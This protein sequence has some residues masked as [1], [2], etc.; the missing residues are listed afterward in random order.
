MLVSQNN[1]AA[2]MLVFQTSP[3]GV[4]HF[5][6]ANAFFCSNK[7]AYKLATWVKTIYFAVFYNYVK[8]IANSIKTK[9]KQAMNTFFGDN[10]Y[11]KAF[12]ESTIYGHTYY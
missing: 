7:F 11:N 5:S 4:E 12:S 2:A 10:S 3:L 9:F 1:E 6:Y 8:R